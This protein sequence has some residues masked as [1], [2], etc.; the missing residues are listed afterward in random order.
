[1]GCLSLVAYFKDELHIIYMN[2][3]NDP[4]YSFGADFRTTFMSLL[5][6]LMLRFVTGQVFEPIGDMLLPE[7]KW[8]PKERQSR[9]ERFSVCMFKLGYF[10]AVSWWGF[11]MLR[12]EPWTPVVLGG[13]GDIAKAGGQMQYHVLTDE[14]RVY[15][16]V[17]L[18]YHMQSFIM[19]FTLYHRSDFM[20]MALHHMCTIFLVGFSYG[21][22]YWR[23]GALVFFI[24]DFSD[25]FSYAIKAVVDTGYTSIILSVYACLLVSWGYLRLYVLPFY[26]LR[27]CFVHVPMD[28]PATNMLRIFLSVLQLLHVYWYILF[29]YMGLKFATSGKAE[30]VQENL[31]DKKNSK[32][33]PEQQAAVQALLKTTALKPNTEVPSSKTKA[34]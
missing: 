14:W 20:E 10:V 4:N 22:N 21:A 9:V 34:E 6:F 18:S 13:S 31:F 8:S 27:S 3:V 33:T 26:I 16:L 2:R 25:V 29:L 12:D 24:H 19:Q 15:Y 5:C 1:M 17:Q 7:N 30:D 32:L 28:A 11:M 23:V